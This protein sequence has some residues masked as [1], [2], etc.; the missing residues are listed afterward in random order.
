[1]VE[2]ICILGCNT[3]K[4]G[5]KLTDVSEKY[6]TSIFSAGEKVKQENSMKQV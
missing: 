1:M 6:I 5:E 4:Y 3:L 2:E